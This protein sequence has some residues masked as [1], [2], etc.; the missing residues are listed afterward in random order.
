VEVKK[1]DIPQEAEF[2][3]EFWK[4]AKKYYIPEDTDSYWHDAIQSLTE[5]SKKYPSEFAKNIILGFMKYLEDKFYK[6]K[7]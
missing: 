3:T 4:V 1:S 2:M 7:Q 5:L 6:R